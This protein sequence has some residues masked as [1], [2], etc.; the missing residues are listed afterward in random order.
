MYAELLQD[1]AIQELMARAETEGH[2]KTVMV[3]VEARFPT[4]VEE[5]QEVVSQLN[6]PSLLSWL[7]R[8]MASAPDEAKARWALKTFAA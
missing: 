6:S 8:M 7:G 3:I 5:T 1:P 4:L 2:R